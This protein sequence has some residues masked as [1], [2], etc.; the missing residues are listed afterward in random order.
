MNA[1]G[2]LA[3]GIGGEGRPLRFL[4][5]VVG[6]WSGARIA[7]L[8]PDPALDRVVAARRIAAASPARQPAPAPLIALG[9]AAASTIARLSLPR[10]TAIVTLARRD[11]ATPLVATAPARRISPPLVPVIATV[12]SAPIAPLLDAQA[13]GDAAQ[14]VAATLPRRARWSGSGWALVRGSGAAGGVATPQL[15]GGQVGARLAYRLDR[16]GRVAAVARVAAALGTRQQEAA[17]GVEWQPTRLPVRLV[18]EQRI[19]VAGIRGGPALGLVGGVGALPLGAGLQA[20]GYAQ[21]GVVARNRADGYVDGALVIARPVV[22]RDAMHV[23]LGVGAWGAA[24]RRASRLDL[25]PAAIV[26]L[27]VD[28]RAIRIGIQWRER[29]AGNARPGSGAVLSLGTDF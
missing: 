15:G 10:E 11:R 9:S 5:L 26:V 29:V 12:A 16:S 4:M 7:L 3:R 13:G 8:W 24:Q 18:A 19:G 20:D 23:E 27:P 21:A 14:P 28:R 1:R 25:G 2:M 17:L 22:T 6:G